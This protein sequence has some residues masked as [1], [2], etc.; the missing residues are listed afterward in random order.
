M[1]TQID[2]RQ[3]RQ[4]TVLD[5]LS[6]DTNLRLDTILNL[7]NDEITMPLRMR[8]TS[9]A[10]HVLNIDAISVV[11]NDST[12]G[13]QRNRVVPP[14]G[15]QFVLP[16]FTGGTITLPATNNNNITISTGGTVLLNILA[17]GNY[18]LMLVALKYDG[19]LQ[20]SL[21]SDE[22]TNPALLTMPVA[23]SN[24]FQIG[25]YLIK[26]TGGNIDVV[27]ND[28]IYQFVGGGGSG[29]VGASQFVTQASHGFVVGDLVYVDN[30][31]V[32]AKAL[33]TADTTMA[34]GMVALVPSINDFI[35]QFSGQVNTLSGLV[36]GTTYYLSG[37]T[38]GASVTT[39]YFDS[40]SSYII[41]A[42]YV[43]LSSTS[44][45][46]LPMLKDPSQEQVTRGLRSQNDPNLTSATVNVASG[47]SL[48]HPNLVIGS[49]NTYNISGTLVCP[50]GVSGAGILAGTGN[51]I[52]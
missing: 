49:G 19:T 33:A 38:A 46:L 24:A 4:R 25:Y 37:A 6:N 40:S 32:W 20:I 43:A 44:A 9:T 12:L 23:I 48:I 16:T 52:S 14:I 39:E 29:G 15:A 11:T 2:A 13:H 1:S 35:V 42:A 34:M 50:G 45:V 18:K 26:R 10:D 5:Q 8:A 22:N 31:G 51:I 3:A 47:F 21:S 27:S 30:S 28:K 17:S 7:I 36:A 41:Q